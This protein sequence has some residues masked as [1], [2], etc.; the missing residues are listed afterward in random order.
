[1]NSRGGDSSPLHLVFSTPVVTALEAFGSLN[2]T[3]MCMLHGDSLCG[4]FWFNIHQH[5]LILLNHAEKAK[6]Y[7]SFFRS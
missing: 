1:M 4:C 6:Q 7:L 2:V 5:L 3:F